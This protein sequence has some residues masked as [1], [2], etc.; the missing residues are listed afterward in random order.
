M[1]LF[2]RDG[3]LQSDDKPLLYK[4]ST[5]PKQS[6]RFGG[7]EYKNVIHHTQT[8][9]DSWSRKIR[10]QFCS[11]SKPTM[12]IRFAVPYKLRLLENSIFSSEL[13]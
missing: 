8:L 1:P 11:K 10:T 4:I 13:S 7:L 12:Y 6:A 5:T 2:S 3:Q 9:G